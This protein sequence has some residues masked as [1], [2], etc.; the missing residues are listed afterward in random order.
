MYFDKKGLDKDDN[1]LKNA[2]NLFY[3]YDKIAIGKTNNFNL[4]L[5]DFPLAFGNIMHEDHDRLLIDENLLT[6]NGQSLAYLSYNKLNSNGCH[7][8][9]SS[10]I[11]EEDTHS[12]KRMYCQILYLYS[13]SKTVLYAII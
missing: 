8:K 6:D 5:K 2:I 7:L 13:I 9:Y 1:D 10:I 11:S 4:F 12:K 3:K